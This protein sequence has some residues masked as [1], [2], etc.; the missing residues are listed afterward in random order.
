MQTL[1]SSLDQNSISDSF[2]F[3]KLYPNSRPGEIALKRAFDLINKHRIIP[4]PINE[5][6]AVP[7]FYIQGLIS[8]VNKMPFD[9]TP[10][11]TTE[12]IQ[13]IKTLSDHLS[14]RKLKGSKVSSIEEIQ[15]LPN[16]QI[17]LARALLLY[18]FTDSPTKIHD[19]EQ[20]E[21]N[22]DLMALQILARLPRGASHLEKIKAIN[23]FIFH[24]MRFRFPPQSLSTKQI[25]TYTILPSVL[26]NRLGVCLG[27][28]ILY[29]TLAQ[30]MNL[31]LEIITPPGHIYLSYLDVDG[32]RINIETTSRGIHIP[33]EHYYGM[34]TLRLQKRTIKET[35]GLSF[36]NQASVAW[37]QKKYEEA[38]KLYTAAAPYMGEDSQLHL[39]LGINLLNTDCISEAKEHLKKAHQIP[40]DEVLFQDTLSEDFLAGRVDKEGFNAIFKQIDESRQSIFEKQKL[41]QT[42]MKRFPKFREG[43]LALAVTWLQLS[44]M[45]EALDA[46]NQYHALDPNNPTVEYYLAII[47]LQRFNYA[48]A[49]EHLKQTYKIIGQLK[50]QN[51][52]LHPLNFELHLMNFKI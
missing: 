15:K 23:Q 50:P 24:E 45:K 34:N 22:L 2:A 5:K 33:E 8:L 31:P 16:E 49:F 37:D 43:W 52:I 19:I 41:I 25:D 47:H 46:L 18:Q 35:I 1:F 3:Y 13:L 44:R 9:Q 48:K 39:F 4:I 40:M 20:Y 12:Q 51:K 10:I 36:F 38:V 11:L 28:S 6:L 14:N 27:V 7:D 26:D 42:Q 32:N 17:D 21:A 30:R 29:L